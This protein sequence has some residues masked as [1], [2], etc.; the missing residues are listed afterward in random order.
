VPEPILDQPRVMARVG[1]SIAAGMAEHMGVDQ[2]G[3]ASSL[4]DALDEAVDGVG[5][6]RPAPLCLEHEGPLRI[7]LQ[8]A[9]RA[10]QIKN[11]SK[12]PAAIMSLSIV[13]WIA[14]PRFAKPDIDLMA[15][16]ASGWEVLRYYGLTMRS[17]RRQP[18]A[19]AVG[20]SASRC[21]RHSCS[22]SRRLHFSAVLQPA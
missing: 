21:W 14:Y 22:G 5:G 3:E 12:I 20:S 8:F 4:A 18:S 13:G 17:Q 19:T 10:P 9:Q 16:L 7:P 2:E 6:E 1:H 11:Y 15:H